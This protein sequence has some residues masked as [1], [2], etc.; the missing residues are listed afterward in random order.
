M[1]NLNNNSDLNVQSNSTV[2]GND[3][4]TINK[5]LSYSSNKDY[6]YDRSMHSLDEISVFWGIPKN[7]I[8]KYNNIDENNYI[9]HIIKIP[10]ENMDVSKL[11]VPLYFKEMFYNNTWPPLPELIKDFNWNFITALWWR[12]SVFLNGI[13][14][15]STLEAI[16]T[17]ELIKKI[18]EKVPDK[19]KPLV[20]EAFIYSDDVL[21]NQ[22]LEENKGKIYL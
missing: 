6:V 14:F 19:Y 1:N 15:Y 3:A 20:S 5:I 10:T 2:P 18:Y 21:I 9:P 17:S 22:K 8:L 7:E 16:N 11:E 4:A 12:L 13:S